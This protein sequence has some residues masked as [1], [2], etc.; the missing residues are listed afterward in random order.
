MTKDVF[1][2][3][4]LAVL[5]LPPLLLFIPI[6]FSIMLLLVPLIPYLISMEVIEKLRERLFSF[7]FVEKENKEDDVKEASGKSEEN[8]KMLK[9]SS[10]IDRYGLIVV[11]IVSITIIIRWDGWV[12]AFGQ[13]AFI[14]LSGFGVLTLK[15]PKK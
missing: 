3:I 8:T 2:Y 11:L 7:F 4:F 15:K 6:G 5:F 1:L 9:C 14:F 12:M 13:M 10:W